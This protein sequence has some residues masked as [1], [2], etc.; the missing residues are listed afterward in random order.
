MNRTCD[1]PKKLFVAFLGINQFDQ[2]GLRFVLV[3]FITGTPKSSPKVVLWR[4]QESTLFV[5]IL[6]INQFCWVGLRYVC[7][8][9]DRNTQRLTESCF[10]GEAGNRTCNPFSGFSGYKPVLPGWIKI[11]VGFIMGTHKGSL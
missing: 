4:S 1:P 6:G 8:F 9:H 3:G 5:A 11:C 2:V 7:W 10:Y